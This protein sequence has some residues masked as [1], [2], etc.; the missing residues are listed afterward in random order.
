VVLDLNLPQLDGIDT[1]QRMRAGH[2]DVRVLILSARSDVRDKVAG[3]D[4]GASDF[5]EK[6]FHFHELDARLRALLRRAFVQRDSCLAH[7][8]VRLD[9]RLRRVTASGQPVHLTNKEYA[10]L[11]YLLTNAGRIVSAEELIDHIWSGDTALF[12]NSLKVH[13]STLNRKMAGATADH[14][15]IKNLRGAGYFIARE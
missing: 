6:P 9:S 13:V 8:D 4:A 14:F 7:G 10:I 2:P 15:A 11:E 12:S 1:L 3:L 5:L